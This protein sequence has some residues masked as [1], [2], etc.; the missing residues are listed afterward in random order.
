MRKSDLD[1]S[2]SIDEAHSTRL[3]PSWDTYVMLYHP[4]EL[5]V[6]EAYRAKIFRQLEGNAP[7]LLIDGVA[8]GTWEKHRERN[9]TRMVVKPF[10]PL[11]PSQKR[12]VEEEASL[13]GECL[14]TNAQVSYST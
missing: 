14:G 10:K 7:V 3:V 12:I 6:P 9:Q 5:L 8:A 2:Q 13:L 1:Q 11:T 4:R